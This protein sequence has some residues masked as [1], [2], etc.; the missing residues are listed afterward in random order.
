MMLLIWGK[1]SGRRQ[2]GHARCGTGRGTFRAL[3]DSTRARLDKVLSI[4][5][6]GCWIYAAER[7]EAERDT[8]GGASRDFKGSV[9][10][11]S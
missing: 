4:F 10:V 7:Q 3:A 5:A 8:V 9:V 1:G 2:R 11:A 6:R